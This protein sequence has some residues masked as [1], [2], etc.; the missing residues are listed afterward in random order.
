MRILT[1]ILLSITLVGCKKESNVIDTTLKLSITTTTSKTMDKTLFV[2]ND[3]IDL[4]QWTSNNQNCHRGD[5]LYDGNMWI[6]RSDLLWEDVST[7]HF[8]I[9]LYPK[10]EMILDN[11]QDGYIHY[12]ISKD[13]SLLCARVLD[14]G[15]IATQGAVP[16]E[17]KY[18]ASCL[19]VD[20]EYGDSFLIKPEVLSLTLKSIGTVAEKLNLK[21]EIISGELTNFKDTFLYKIELD[22]KYLAY[23]IPQQV[24]ELELVLSYNGKKLMYHKQ[25][26]LTL[27]SGKTHTVRFK[28]N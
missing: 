6:N 3:V 20:L 16:L 13:S 8:F 22:N 10:T 1:Y 27:E 7:A 9:S 19:I 15:R 5:F 2:A 12:D 14:T 25:I 23:V 24:G 11:Q 17:F 18:L 28:M 21:S 26:S 4:Y